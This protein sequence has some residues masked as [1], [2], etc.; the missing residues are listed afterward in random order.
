M[1]VPIYF[2]LLIKNVKLNTLLTI[3]IIFY[4]FLMIFQSIYKG[5]KPF[6]KYFFHYEQ[7]RK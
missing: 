6:G 1:R 7:V 2:I 5:E 4:Y 3:K